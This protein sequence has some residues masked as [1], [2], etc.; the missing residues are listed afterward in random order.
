MRHLWKS[1]LR[2]VIPFAI[3][4]VGF[5]AFA[6]EPVPTPSSYPN[7]IGTTK[8]ILTLVNVL[9]TYMVKI[10][11]PLAGLAVIIAGLNYVLAAASGNSGRITKANQTLVWVLIGTGLVVG[12]LI[13]A[14]AVYNF[15][16]GL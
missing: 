3:I 12:A 5:S 2:F 7:P 16:T 1:S 4:L 8:D 6:Q 13:I 11:I 15:I 14:K 9:L 10:T